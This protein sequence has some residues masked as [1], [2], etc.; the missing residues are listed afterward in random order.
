MSTK[1][2]HYEMIVAWAEGKEVE[3]RPAGI[4]GAYDSWERVINPHVFD[5]YNVFRIKPK[6]VKTVGYQR[7]VRRAGDSY[8]VDSYI[9]DG[10]NVSPSIFADFVQWIDTEPKQEVVEIK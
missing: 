8:V 5:E 7:Y 9:L 3:Y 4:D 6:Q 1:H 2:Q 10:E